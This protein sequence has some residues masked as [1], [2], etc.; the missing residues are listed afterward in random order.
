M[1]TYPNDP[2]MGWRDTVKIVTEEKEVVKVVGGKEH[3]EMKKWSYFELS[4]YK[5]WTYR[6]LG[7][8]VKQVAGGLVAT[9]HKRHH[10]VNIYSSTKKEWQA[11][12]NG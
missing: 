5:Y 3:K 1:E 10:V 4:D 9:G 6:E 8:A 7:E 11:F 2:A 12:A